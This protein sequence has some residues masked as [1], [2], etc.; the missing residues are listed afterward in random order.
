MK[1]IVDGVMTDHRVRCTISFVRT[2]E[3][4]LRSRSNQMGIGQYIAGIVIKNIDPE[5]FRFGI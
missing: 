4:K 5:D 3:K 2:A 1:K